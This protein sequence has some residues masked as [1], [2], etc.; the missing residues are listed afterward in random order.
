MMLTQVSRTARLL[1]RTS[2]PNRVRYPDTGPTGVDV[3]PLHPDLTRV[4]SDLA[5]RVT[6]HQANL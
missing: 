6:W 3:V 2:C 4:G 5:H 1:V